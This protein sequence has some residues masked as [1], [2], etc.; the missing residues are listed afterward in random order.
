[1]RAGLAGTR[2]IAR[3]VMHP[4]HPDVVYVAAAGH[5]WGSNSER[6][7]F[8]TSDGGRTWAKVLY[9]DDET[10]ATDLAI[11]P[12]DP[13]T[14]FAA[15]YQR[16]RKAWGFNGGGPGSGIYRTRDGG[17]TWTRLTTGLP[18]G[19]KGRIGVDIFRG[20]SRIVF[21]VVEAAGR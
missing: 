8:K 6:G 20:D 9:V 16:Q 2:H 7:V 1:M 14:L 4:R 3:V 21:A 10:G 11:D 5:L 19:D 13:Q 15:M 12:R 17:A 18:A